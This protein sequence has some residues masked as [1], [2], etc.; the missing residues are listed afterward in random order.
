MGGFLRD[1][2]GFD[3]EVALA[4]KVQKLRALDVGKLERVNSQFALKVD[5]MKLAEEKEI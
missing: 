2:Y 5:M 3:S 4:E 1:I